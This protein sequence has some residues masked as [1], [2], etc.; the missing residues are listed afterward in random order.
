MTT[1]QKLE[2]AI[3]EIK[4]SMNA[5]DAKGREYG[6]ETNAVEVKVYHR[7]YALLKE[8]DVEM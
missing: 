6:Y 5:I 1:E 7:L 3:L 2:L 8:L 4:K